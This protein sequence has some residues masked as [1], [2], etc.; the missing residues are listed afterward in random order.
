MIRM[1]KHVYRVVSSIKSRKIVPITFLSINFGLY[2][3]YGDH[4]VV[5]LIVILIAYK[6]IPNTNTNSNSN[7]Y[8]YSYTVIVILIDTNSNTNTKSNRLIVLL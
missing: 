8:T 4:D 3:N 5:I 6:L 2:F 1:H 7:T